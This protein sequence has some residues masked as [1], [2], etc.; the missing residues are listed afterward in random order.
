MIEEGI[1]LEIL[2]NIQDGVYYVDKNRVIQ[3]WNKG[4]EKITGYTSE[5][6]VGLTC[7]ETYLNHIDEEGKPLCIV[8][9]PLY[10]TNIDGIVRTEKV[11]VR[12]KEGYRIPIVVNI[13]PI[14]KDGEIIGSVEVFSVNSPKVYE[15][16]LIEDLSGKAMHDS[17]TKLPNRSYVESFLA[18]KLAELERFGKRF[19]LLFV[20]IDHFRN[21]NNEYGH[22]VGDMVLT[23][24][25]K[26][27][28]HN[29]KK[30]DMFGRWGGE[31]FVGIFSIDRSYEASIIAERIR[32]LVEN[33][34]VT[35]AKNEQLAVTVSVGAAISK[36]QDTIDTLI[37]RADELMYK[38]KNDGRNR[39]SVQIPD[40]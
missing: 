22:D 3:F 35:T 21:F 6:V 27:I 38:S 12:H 4:A 33:T 32:Y 15:D 1:S 25:A 39:V 8:G 17:L 28:S 36:K 34:V 20:D 26:G 10:A 31:E 29:I 40:R 2:N 19:A 30:D 23:A 5:E 37:K 13:S 24:I 7:P 14:R 9:C 11:F 18:Y 16:D